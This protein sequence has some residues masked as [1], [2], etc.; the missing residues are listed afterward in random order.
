MQLYKSDASL[1]VDSLRKS[2]FER[3]FEFNDPEQPIALV[4]VPTGRQI[5]R[6]E[7]KT[8]A[9]RFAY[10]IRHLSKLGKGDDLQKGDVISVFSTNTIDYPSIIFGALA[11]GTPIALSSAAQTPEELA[12]QLK[13]T[14]PSFF[15][16]H[17]ALMPIFIKTMALIGFNKEI[18]MRRTALIDTSIVDVPASLRD[19]TLLSDLCNHGGHFIPEAFNGP[20]ASQV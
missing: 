12:H 7:L 4:D 10:G 9:L 19:W 18:C 16:V 3:C 1:D 13:I 17:S 8:Q 2:A 5:T 14:K 11:A 15:I 20:D 6:V